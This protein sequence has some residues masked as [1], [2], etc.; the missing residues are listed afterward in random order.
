MR[1]LSSRALAT[2]MHP[3]GF[4][5]I[6]SPNLSL[7]AIT[8]RRNVSP[9]YPLNSAVAEFR[10]LDAKSGTPDLAGEGGPDAVGGGVGWG[11]NV[12]CGAAHKLVTPPGR[13]SAVHPP[14]QGEG[15]GTLLGLDLAAR[16]K[17]LPPAPFAHERKDELFE[18]TCG[19]RPIAAKLCRW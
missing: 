1:F 10:T 17:E 14:H 18:S 15:E 2:D 4:G 8:L 12:V 9:P 19:F 6:C 11:V 5:S 3:P 13:P 16:E 7:E